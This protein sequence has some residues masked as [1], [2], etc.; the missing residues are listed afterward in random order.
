MCALARAPAARYQ[1]AGEFAAAL[2]PA[3]DAALAP[4]AIRR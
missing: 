1:S 3:A 4:G 2:E